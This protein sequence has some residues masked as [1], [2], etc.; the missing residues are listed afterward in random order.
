MIVIDGS[1]AILGRLATNVAKRLLKRKHVHIINAEKMVITGTPDGIMPKFRTRMEISPKGNPHKGP[2]YSRMPDRIVRRAIRGMLPWKSP[3]GKAAFKNL[4]VHIGVPEELGG[5][6]AEKIEA[7]ASRH[8]K[9]F[10]TI[11]E[12]SRMLGAKW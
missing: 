12:I 10:M 9:G 3:S 7:A 5:K 6:Q 11:G 8:E 2:K 4:R 1:N